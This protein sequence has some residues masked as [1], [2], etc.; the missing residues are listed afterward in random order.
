MTNIDFRLINTKHINYDRITNY[1]KYI[2]S[3]TDYLNF[4][5]K[6]KKSLKYWEL[7]VGSWLMHFIWLVDYLDQTELKNKQGI[8][9]KDFLIPYDYKSFISLLNHPTEYSQLIIEIIRDRK[10]ILSKKKKVLKFRLFKTKYSKKIFYKIFNFFINPFLRYSETIMISPGISFFSQVKIFLMTKFKVSPI[11]INVD[12]ERNTFKKLSERK[13]INKKNIFDNRL[14]E[15]LYEIILL[16]IPYVYV[17]GYKEIKIES[18]VIKNLYRLKSIFST[19]GWQENDNFK[20]MA[21]EA[22]EKK[23]SLVAMQHGGSP[24][25]TGEDPTILQ[26]TE[27]VDYFITWGWKNRSHHIP[28]GNINSTNFIK[29]VNSLRKNQEKESIIFI[30]TTGSDYWPDGI[31][32][33]SGEQWSQYYNTQRKFL[34]KIKDEMF[35]KIIF[36]LHPFHY[37][38]SYSQK[39]NLESLF[40]NINIDK[41]RSLETTL[42]NAKYVVLDNIQTVFYQILTCNIPVVVIL[43]MDLWSFNEKFSVIIKQMQKFSILH[44]SLESAVSFLEENHYQINDWWNQLEIQKLIKDLCNDYCKIVQNPESEIVN[45]LININKK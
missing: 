30:S 43:D 23:I 40:P 28:L 35:K 18:S 2:N 7:I 44:T 24:H 36:R 15:I 42:K 1:T 41:N 4:I 13:W 3:L 27:L 26:E 17:E 14:D 33:P 12:D 8:E 25:G 37:T 22:Y 9:I 34:K 21:A 16:Q 29:N 45:L 32:S 6:E 10:N 38:S 39:K 19:Y 5:H 31:G 20:F 11:F